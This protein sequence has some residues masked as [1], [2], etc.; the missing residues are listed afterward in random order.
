MNKHK[1]SF[2]NAAKIS[3]DIDQLLYLRQIGKSRP[4]DTQLI[5]NL[6]ALH[7][8]IEQ[9]GRKIVAVDEL[10]ESLLGI[11]YFFSNPLRAA[12]SNSS[13]LVQPDSFKNPQVLRFKNGNFNIFVFD[14]VLKSAALNELRQFFK[15]AMIWFEVKE[16]LTYL[17]TD[18]RYGMNSNL[19]LQIQKELQNSLQSFFGPKQVIESWAIKYDLTESGIPAHADQQSGCYTS[20]FWSTPN[21]SNRDQLSGGM[22]ILNLVPPKDWPW[23]VA[24]TDRERIS[25][26]IAQ[27]NPEEISIPYKTNRLILFNSELLHKTDNIKFG[28]SYED[29]RVS[30]T[31]IYK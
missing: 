11:D 12:E 19:L 17:Y 28:P 26:Y 16:S 15:E 4:Q 31:H 20:N 10:I 23:P 24:I 18:G 21:T 3:H 5:E 6:K 29:R 22:T 13:D 8:L 27:Q 9:S 7:S 2:I 14:E 1:L 25:A 30:L